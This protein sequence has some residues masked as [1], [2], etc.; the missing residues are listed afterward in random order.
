MKKFVILLGLVA[1]F[2]MV[3]GCAS[4]SATDQ[5]VSATETTATTHHDFKGEV[6][7]KK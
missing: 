2:G 5:N 6:S 4:K 1:S 3:I 7:S